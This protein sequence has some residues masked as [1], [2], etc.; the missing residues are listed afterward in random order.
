M[1]NRDRARFMRVAAMICLG[2]SLICWFQPYRVIHGQYYAQR[3]WP[4]ANGAIIRYEEHEGDE[5][6]KSIGSSRN[7]VYWIEFEV[8]F[9]ATGE[10]CHTGSLWDSAQHM[11]FPCIGTI[12]TFPTRSLADARAWTVR[13]QPGSP[14]RILYDPNSSRVRFADESPWGMY[15][16]GRIAMFLGLTAFSILFYGATQQRL[17]V[18]ADLPEDYDA[19]PPPSSGDKTDDLVDLNLR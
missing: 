13:H 10:Q 14:A 12:R 16:P 11:P 9:A 2:V 3:H 19:T 15:P 18:L 1:P 4:V 8:E 5:R 7:T 17:R 6:G